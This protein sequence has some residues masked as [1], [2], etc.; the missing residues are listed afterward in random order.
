MNYLSVSNLSKQY[1]DKPLFLS[2]SFGL[3]KGD[4]MAL[5]ASNGSGK[6]TLMKVLMGKEMADDGSFVFQ[7]GIRLGYLEQQP[8]FPSGMSVRE[9]VH[10]HDSI[11]KNTIREYEEALKEQ[12]V[13][14]SPVNREKVAWYTNL[15]DK[16]NAWDYERR[17]TEMLTRF[18][19]TDLTQSTETLSGG[20]N[21]RLALALALLDNPELLLL[22][23]PTNHMDLEMIEW[24]EQYLSASDL[25]LLMV[26]HDRYFLDRVCNHILEIEQGKVY[27]H[28]GNYGYFL[29]KKAQRMEALQVERNK[30]SKRLKQEL[31]WLRRM[32]K[33]RTHKSKARID[34]YYETKERLQNI[35]TGQQEIVLQNNMS[36]QGGKIIEVHH[37]SKQYGDLKIITD[38]EYLFKKGERIGIVGKNGVGKSTFLNLLTQQEQPDSGEVIVG[39]TTVMGY[40]TQSGLDV[41]QDKTVLEVVK[42]IAEVIV[43]GKNRSMTASQFLNYFLFPPKVQMTPVS[44]L[45][46]GELRRLHLLTVLIKNP[47]FLILDEPTN[48]LDIVTLNK[49]EE[50]LT[51][52]KGCLLL[53]SHDRYFLN[54]LADH[55]FVFEGDGKVKD[56]YGDYNEYKLAREEEE[57]EKRQ[58]LVTEKQPVVKKKAESAKLSYKE[59]REY[60]ALEKEIDKLEE[61]KVQC[62]AIL[63]SGSDDYQELEKASSRISELIQLIDEK[64]FRWMELDE[65]NS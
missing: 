65:R 35:P 1:G 62:E 61:E 43:M 12:S 21:K 17:M 56:F 33:A 19:I 7:D 47:N 59:K 58:Q 45:S 48:D 32:P 42:D 3:Q 57:K 37:L 13:D 46:G 31:E 25:T 2:V 18:G 16:L 10:Q 22:D 6:S 8:V 14:D 30:T 52:F 28:Q 23:E 38:F 34:A 26:T 63:N 9:V 4:K 27:L 24:L 55:L 54:R 64:T 60:E 29:E 44:K 50:F 15:M 53:V 41:N 11:I 5:I 40:Y 49:L 20:Q 36:R 39:D 51:D